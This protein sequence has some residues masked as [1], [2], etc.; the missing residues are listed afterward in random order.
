M[1]FSFFPSW[2][3]PRRKTA[4]K[5]SLVWK[6]QKFGLYISNCHFVIMMLTWLRLVC[7][8]SLWSKLLQLLTDHTESWLALSISTCRYTLLTLLVA[9]STVLRIIYPWTYTG[10]NTV[11]ILL[12]VASLLS[13]FQ[14]IW[15]FARFK[16]LNF[17]ARMFIHF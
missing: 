1:D 4:S 2:I 17:L 13:S 14:V 12:F 10:L 6:V 16:S 9:P 11:E 15:I 3:T 7:V 8:T 5:S